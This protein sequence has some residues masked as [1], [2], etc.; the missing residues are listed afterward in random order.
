MGQMDVS[1]TNIFLECKEQLHRSTKFEALSFTFQWAWQ[2]VAVEQ[3]EIFVIQKQCVEFDLK[4]NK[5]ANF[6]QNIMSFN[7]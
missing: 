1:N 3:T 2:Y 5:H 4:I 6:T 7:Q